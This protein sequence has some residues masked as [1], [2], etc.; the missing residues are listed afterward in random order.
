MTFHE[1][2]PREVW[3]GKRKFSSSALEQM[4]QTNKKKSR[5]KSLRIIHRIEVRLEQKLL[6]ESAEAVSFPARWAR[7]ALTHHAL[8]V[9]TSTQFNNMT[10]HLVMILMS[11][12][13]H[14]RPL[15]QNIILFFC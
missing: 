2:K 1:K 9:M 15:T 13:L 11:K 8:R 5:G 4:H 3:V 7:V 14:F 10:R 12:V 6:Q